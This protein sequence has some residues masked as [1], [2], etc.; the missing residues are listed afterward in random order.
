[1]RV[2]NLSVLIQGNLSCSYHT[3]NSFS[4]EQIQV[5][6]RNHYIYT[7][8]YSERAFILN[9]DFNII[10]THALYISRRSY[11]D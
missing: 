1:M 10:L 2:K 11:Q 4:M 5:I 8:P 7:S 9:T 3:F 6:D